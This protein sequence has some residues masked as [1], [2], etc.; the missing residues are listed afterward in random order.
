[1]ECPS[2]SIKNKTELWPFFAS[3]FFVFNDEKGEIFR[4]VVKFRLVLYMECQ[5]C[6]RDL[7]MFFF[8]SGLI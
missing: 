8:D 6:E 5:S 2:E 7:T 1:M 3:F 4:K